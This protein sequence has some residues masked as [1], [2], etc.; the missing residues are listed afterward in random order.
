MNEVGWSFNTGTDVYPTQH[1]EWFSDNLEA[2]NNAF[3]IMELV[4]TIE[5]LFNIESPGISR[6]NFT[7]NKYRRN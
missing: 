3:H 6:M 1:Y 4:M 7:P 5:M 2:R